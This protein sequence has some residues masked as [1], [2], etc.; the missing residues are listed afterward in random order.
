MTNTE[1]YN[2]YKELIDE[3]QFKLHRLRC[4]YVETNK[5]FNVGDFIGN[6]TGIIKVEKISYVMFFNNVEIVYSGYR[7]KKVNGIL[8]RTKDKK[9]CIMKRENHLK[10]IK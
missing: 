8:S 6:V 7:Y 3:H 5:K 4:E 9:I 1:Y 10:L 2:Q